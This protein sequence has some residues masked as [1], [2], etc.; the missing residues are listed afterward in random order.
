MKHLYKSLLSGGPPVPPASPWS[1]W[2]RSI[3]EERSRHTYSLTKECRVEKASGWMARMAFQLRSLQTESLREARAETH[4][5]CIVPI[6]GLSR[7]CSHILSTW[8]SEAQWP[9]P[10]EEGSYS[11]LVP[12]LAV[13]TGM[14]PSCLGSRASGL[15]G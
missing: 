10:F 5:E 14:Q 2:V 13:A 3:L 7:A 4:G 9:Y 1:L 8:S 12:N 11:C 6:L 15:P